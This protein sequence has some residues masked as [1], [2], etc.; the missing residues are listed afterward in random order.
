MT[1]SLS[2]AL[3]GLHSEALDVEAAALRAVSRH[4]TVLSGRKATQ[5]F[6]AT[7]VAASAPRT[8]TGL[9]RVAGLG[10]LA[11]AVQKGAA[12][13]SHGV[14]AAS[15]SALAPSSV[16]SPALIAVLTQVLRPSLQPAA[17]MAIAWAVQQHIGPRWYPAKHPKLRCL[18]G[19]GCATQQHAPGSLSENLGNL[20][21][22]TLVITASSHDASILSSVGLLAL[23]AASLLALTAAGLLA[24]IVASRLCHN[25]PDRFGLKEDMSV[26]N[27]GADVGVTPETQAV[28]LEDAEAA[29]DGVD[30]RS[31]S[32]ETARHTWKKRV[33]D[34]P[35]SMVEN[36]SKLVA[37]TEQSAKQQESHGLQQRWGKGGKSDPFSS[38]VQPDVSARKNQYA[39]LERAERMSREVDIALAQADDEVEQEQEAAAE[40]MRL[41]AG[42]PSPSHSSTPSR[43]RRKTREMVEEVRQAARSAVDHADSII[44]PCGRKMGVRPPSDPSETSSTSSSAETESVRAPSPGRMRRI[45]S[46]KV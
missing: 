21:I 12:S 43:M 41:A 25:S 16:G 44:L 45:L 18:P 14:A 8:I 17:L 2:S 27:T 9:A 28:M 22:P 3:T 11:L 42:A 46:L 37:Q 39:W 10:P 26:R 6:A 15:T 23:I 36:T 1:P 32:A 4:V 24:L 35:Q 20:P 13:I 38:T 29:V 40:A 5:N 19:A 34:A 33:K 7:T 30:E 31:L